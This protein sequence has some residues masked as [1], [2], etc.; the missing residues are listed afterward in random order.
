MKGKHF[1]VLFFSILIACF[2]MSGDNADCFA[3]EKT[4]R[5]EE[6]KPEE[7]KGTFTL[8][9]YGGSFL[10]DL[11][12]IALLDSEGDH[13]VLDPFVP[14]FDYRIKK[15]VSAQEALKEAENFVTFHPSFWRSQLNRILDKAGK[16]IGY[17]VR[18]L[19]RPFTF[20]ISDVL[21]VNYWLKEKGRVKVT[22]RL[23]PSI[24]KNKLPG[25]DTG[26][27]GGD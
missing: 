8:I 19:Y 11:E 10:D 25:G 14:D 7:M 17:E 1:A 16:T 18:P 21:D 23:I 20:G 2:R 22:I 3:F 4:L 13:Y 24:E 27:A 9:L 26:S 5:T 15:G 12:T 6:A